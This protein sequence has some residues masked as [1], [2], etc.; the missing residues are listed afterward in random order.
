[1]EATSVSTEAL[2]M[3][4]VAVVLAALITLV[5]VYLQTSKT[6]KAERE[7]LDDQLQAEQERLRMQLAHDRATRERGELR[8][9]LDAAAARMDQLAFAAIQAM[10]AAKAFQQETEQ[11]DDTGAPG[12]NEKLSALRGELEQM[13]AQIRS[14]DGHR[15]QLGMR[16]GQDH[17][18]LISYV[19]ARE[20]F[21]KLHFKLY[22]AGPDNDE[23]LEFVKEAGREIGGFERSAFTLI[24][25]E[26]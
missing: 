13:F 16:L 26:L 1:M 6:L 24:R 15:A 2:W 21:S 7:R 18:A 5:G 10:D 12:V 9:V 11:T 23:M 22:K 20:H 19:K 3:G 8:N 4:G 25:S 14:V 17:P